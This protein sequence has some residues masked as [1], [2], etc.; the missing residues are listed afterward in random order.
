MINNNYSA[1][2]TLCENAFIG[3]KHDLGHGRRNMC[4]CD[5]EFTPGIGVFDII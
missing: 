3:A 1:T 4:E 2:L 5:G